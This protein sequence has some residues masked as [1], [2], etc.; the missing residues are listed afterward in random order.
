MMYD[1]PSIIAIVNRPRRPARGRE[2]RKTGGG[3]AGE[4]DG[5]GRAER[6]A[7]CEAEVEECFWG[8]CCGGLAGLF[9]VVE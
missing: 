8:C 1:S 9:G 3:D 6:E 7:F 5:L 2:E 4:E